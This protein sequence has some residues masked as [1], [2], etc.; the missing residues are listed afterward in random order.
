MLFWKPLWSDHGWG[1]LEA[2]Q[3]IAHRTRLSHQ[4]WSSHPHPTPSPAPAH[5]WC[6]LFSTE[7]LRAITDVTQSKRLTSRGDTQTCRYGSPWCFVISLLPQAVDKDASGVNV[8]KIC[9][10]PSF[11]I[12]PRRLW[13]PDSSLLKRQGILGS[14][15]N[16]KYYDGLADYLLFNYLNIRHHSFIVQSFILSHPLWD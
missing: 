14:F 16:A 9:S 11:C 1:A 13:D 15:Q 5:P 2:V 10:Y 7:L 6:H 12:L 3:S 4:P 8:L